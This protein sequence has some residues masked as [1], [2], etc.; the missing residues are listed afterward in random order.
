MWPQTTNV[1]VLDFL[2]GHRQL[3]YLASDLISVPLSWGQGTFS[4]K[5]HNILGFLGHTVSVTTTQ[6]CH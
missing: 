3:I 6:I 4:L 1:L 5:D 2:C